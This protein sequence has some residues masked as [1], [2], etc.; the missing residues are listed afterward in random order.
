VGELLGC[1]ALELGEELDRPVEVVGP[2]LDQLLAGALGEPLR[3]ASVVLR[4]G[5]LGEAGVR[6]LA[7]ER[8]LEPVRGLPR[9]GGAR[10]RRRNSRWRRSSSSAS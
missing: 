10:S 3:E 5:E 1:G 9:D 8:V 6:D 2:D 4:A 7:D